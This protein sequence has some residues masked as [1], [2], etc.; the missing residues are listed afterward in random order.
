[1]KKIYFSIIVLLFLASCGEEDKKAKLAELKKQ[2]SELADEIKAL[3][4]ELALSDTTKG[5]QKDI[6]VAAILPQ[7]FKHYVEI[8]GI[9]DADGFTHSEEGSNLPF[10]LKEDFTGMIKKGTPMYQII[11]F[12]RET[13]KSEAAKFNANQQLTVTQS[14]KQFMWGGYKNL[15]WNK[16][17]FD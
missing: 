4:A 14:V 6:L 9:V 1:M 15:V 17:E 5:K 10:L 11:P 12:K 7:A 16:K 2:H 8:Q 13:W 3:E